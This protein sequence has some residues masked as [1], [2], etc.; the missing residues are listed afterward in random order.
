MKI[1]ESVDVLEIAEETERNASAKVKQFNYPVEVKRQVM[2][3]CQQHSVQETCDK[4]GVSV[5]SIYRWKR[6]GIETVRKTK[7][8]ENKIKKVPVRKREVINKDF[9][10]EILKCKKSN[11]YKK[12]CRIFNITSHTLSKFKWAKEVTVEDKKIFIK[13]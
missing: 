9:M 6:E 7:G 13:D 4:L 11:G 8:I 1:T 10:L 12:T 5:R 3:Y 2:N